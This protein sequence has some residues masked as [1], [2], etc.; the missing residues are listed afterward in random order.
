MIREE[1]RKLIEKAAQESSFGVPVEIKIESPPEESHGDYS[2]NF[3]LLI[4]KFVKIAPREIAAH[5]KSHIFNLRPDLFE[6]IE[7]VEPGF[8]NLFV[9][10]K[11]LQN[12]ATEILKQKDKFGC[13]DLG[14][15]RRTNVEF[16]SA[17]P[18]GPLHIGNGRSAFSGDVLSNVLSAAGFSVTREY[19]INDAKN[20]KQIIE[21]GKTALGQGE[22]YL[23]EYLKEKILALAGKASDQ[24]AAGE[25]GFLL[26]KE[27]HADNRNLLEKKLKIKFNKWVSEER[28]IYKKNKIKKTFALLRQKDFLYHQDE[29]WW[30]KSSQFGDDKDWVVIRETGEPTYLLSDIAY[31]QDKIERGFE[32]II[33]IWGAD[34]QAH[35]RKLRAAM[36]MLGFRGELDILV[37]QLVTLRGGEKLSKRKGQI[38]ML[39][40]LVDEIGLDA[41]RFFYLQKS[42]DTHME[43]D[44]SLA[45]EQSIKNPVYYVQYAHARICSILDK[46]GTR[47]PKAEN[48]SLLQHSSELKLIKRLL[49]LPEV[50]E[51]TA[52]DCQLQRLPNYAVEL[53]TVFHQF[54]HDCQVISE[55]QKLTQARLTLVLAAKIVF[56][57][58]L[59]LMGIS[60][61]EKM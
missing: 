57:N 32:K 60:A 13:L 43:I 23:S 18:T 7:I 12:Q 35:V 52:K 14:K 27:V 40:E 48:L 50:V 34:H 41:A 44:I 21:L 59:D 10:Q 37:L 33:D 31:H 45:K 30:I 42:L 11:F 55:N 38:V 26:A 4:A 56:K 53:A 20:S 17:N 54:Y 5:L 9:A 51:D 15:N 25:A 8:I 47:N 49:K 61:P 1:I 3:S 22:V 19:F 58:T 46:A 39:E 16:V 29:A 24:T 28:D 6:K 36:N 2:T